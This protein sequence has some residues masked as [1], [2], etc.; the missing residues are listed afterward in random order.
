MMTATEILNEIRRLSL[1]E[2]ETV[3]KTL[4][5]ELQSKNEISEDE[6]KEQE[7]DRMLISRGLMRETP[8]GITDEE[9]YF[10]PISTTGKP[11]SEIIIEERR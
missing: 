3:L 10:D 11:L 7:V 9:E 8:P 4:E 1:S 6:Q 5:T 2:K